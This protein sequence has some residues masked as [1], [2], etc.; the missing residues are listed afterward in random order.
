MLLWHDCSF[1]LQ[2]G[3]LNGEGGGRISDEVVTVTD[4]EQKSEGWTGGDR[5][6]TGWKRGQ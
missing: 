6:T 3:D 4:E 5:A 2:Q 1:M